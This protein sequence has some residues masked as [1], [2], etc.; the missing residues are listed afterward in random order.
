MVWQAPITWTVGQTVTA[1]QLNAQIRDNMNLTP[2]A[3]ATT[4]GSIFVGTGVNAVA[5]RL[6]LQG[7]VDTQETTTSTS[8]TDLATTGPAV[9]L[10]TGTQAMVW[11]QSLVA[12]ST[13]GTSQVSFGITGATT[14]AP[15]SA[16]SLQ[17][18]GLTAG[19]APRFGVGA[20]MAVTPGSNVFTMKYLVSS[21]TGTFSRRRIQVMGL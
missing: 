12:N 10:T 5:E 3:L 15:T 2:A 8:F 18:D 4:A 9:T 14:D 1:A 16:R 6:F 7:I 13:A 20:L 21:G 17:G 19:G 11:I